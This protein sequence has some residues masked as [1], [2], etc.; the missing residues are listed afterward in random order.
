MTFERTEPFKADYRR[1]SENERA[2]FRSAAR[3]FNAATDRFVETRDP[4]SWPANVRVKALSSAPGIFSSPLPAQVSGGFRG[5][6][7]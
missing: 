6:G 1:L 2:K 4:S 3:V 7:L 5:I